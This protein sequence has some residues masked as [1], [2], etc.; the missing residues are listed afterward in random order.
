VR[1]SSLDVSRYSEK[2]VRSSREL[3][4]ST[5]FDLSET[6]RHQCERVPLG[7]GMMLRTSE[8]VRPGRRSTIPSCLRSHRG[9]SVHSA[10][11]ASRAVGITGFIDVTYRSGTTELCRCGPRRGIV[12]VGRFSKW[13]TSIGLWRSLEAHL[14]WE[15]GVVSSNLTSPTRTRER[16]AFLRSYFVTPFETSPRTRARARLVLWPGDRRHADPQLPGCAYAGLVASRRMSMAGVS[17]PSTER[18]DS[19]SVTMSRPPTRG[20][21]RSSVQRIWG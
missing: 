21:I 14:L 11:F 20:A 3:D 12:P 6:S 1:P 17:E 7:T 19:L 18:R 13:R 8:L 15:Q 5:R 16:I 10:A 4:S 2:V 9:R